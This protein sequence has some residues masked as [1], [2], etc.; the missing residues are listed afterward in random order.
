VDVGAGVRWELGDHLGSVRDVV[1]ADGSTILDHVEYG[2][3]GTIASETNSGNGGNYLYTG[4]RLDR[5]TGIVFANN[6]TLF[7][8]TGQWMQED[9]IQF[10]AGD[11]NLRRYVRNDPTNQIDPDGLRALDVYVAAKPPFILR[12]NGFSGK[13]LD[14]LINRMVLL[15]KELDKAIS[16]LSILSYPLWLDDDDAAEVARFNE[17]KAGLKKWFGEGRNLT[18][19]EV[20][21]VLLVFYA[22]KQGIRRSIKKPIR[23]DYFDHRKLVG[24]TLNEEIPI[25]HDIGWVYDSFNVYKGFFMGSPRQQVQWLFHEM[26]HMYAETEDVAYNL[27]PGKWYHPRNR[28]ELKMTTEGHLFNAQTYERFF[29]E[30][31]LQHLSDNPANNE[32]IL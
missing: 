27:R 16:M 23:F 28:H 1:S 24:P 22:V 10:S 14:L 4:L 9:P 2:P 18:K 6:R 29:S 12:V 20:D 17:I 3:F 21:K 8:T 32:A 15:E 25:E 26:T 7:V 31:F 13:Q 5:A 11:A 30:F 19:R